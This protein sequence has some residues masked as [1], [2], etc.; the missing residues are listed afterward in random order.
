MTTHADPKLPDR[1]DLKRA[2]ERAPMPTVAK[3]VLYALARKMDKGTLV[4]PLYRMPSLTTLAKHSGWS[5]RHVERALNYL[6]LLR[7]VTRNRPSKIDAQTKHAR[8]AYVVHLDPLLWLGTGSPKESK[9]AVAY[10]LGPPRRP[11]RAKKSSALGTGSLEAGDMV[12]HS[13]V[14]PDKPD[15]PDRQIAIVIDVLRNRTG[16][17]VSAEWAAQTRDLILARPGAMGQRPEGYLRRILMLEE[18]AR[19]MAA[20]LAAAA[21]SPGEEIK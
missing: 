12:A 2:I 15:K 1:F 6:E 9:D 14:L 5:R 21:I 8:T 20:D 3:D 16:K 18:K 4:I 17:T 10:G 7:I 13:Q 11:P 19:P